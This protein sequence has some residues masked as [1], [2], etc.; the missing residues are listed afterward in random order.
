MKDMLTAVLEIVELLIWIGFYYGVVKTKLDGIGE[1]KTM[2]SELNKRSTDSLVGAGEQRIINETF[3][4]KIELLHDRVDI[5]DTAIK[6]L[7]I[8]IA[9][10][11]R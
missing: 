5:H 4:D 6:S 10:K 8:N 2:I 3:R 1:L 11:I 7:E 9:K